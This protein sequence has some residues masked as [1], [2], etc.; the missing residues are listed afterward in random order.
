MIKYEIEP[1]LAL[2]SHLIVHTSGSVH[3]YD[4]VEC[5]TADALNKVPLVNARVPLRS[6]REQRAVGVHPRGRCPHAALSASTGIKA[7]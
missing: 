6:E 1:S 3:R 5:M 2:R 7:P 4:A